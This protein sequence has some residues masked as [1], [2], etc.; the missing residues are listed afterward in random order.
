MN[1]L[2]RAAEL[3][4]V[5]YPHRNLAEVLEKALDVFLEKI[6]PQQRQQRRQQRQARKA[7]K[8]IDVTPRPDEV[9][10]ES[11]P[12]EAEIQPGN[13]SRHIPIAVR[14]RLLE[15]A[16]QRCEYVSP[17]GL[18]CTERT[19]LS[20]DHIEPWGRGGTNEEP[21]LRVYCQPHNRLHA[22]R[23][24]GTQFIHRRI[25]EARESKGQRWNGASNSPPSPDE[26]PPPWTSE[27]GECVR[28]ELTRYGAAYG[29]DRV[30]SETS[31]KPMYVFQ[32][33]HDRAYVISRS[34]LRRPTNSG[35]SPRAKRRS[36]TRWATSPSRNGPTDSAEEAEIQGELQAT[37]GRVQ[38]AE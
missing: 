6:D 32:H 29:G 20:I 35:P 12:T 7:K 31:G 13:R 38:G 18:R 37:D 28:E 26:V 27:S 5:T 34:S 22:E 25:A 10:D 15:R 19:A 16:E 21:N 23:C 11:R 14:D 8:V 3:C 9:I 2:E 33:D 24:Y 1:K 4:G 36:T 30:R 17:D